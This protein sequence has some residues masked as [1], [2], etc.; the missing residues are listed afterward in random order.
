M[1]FEDEGKKRTV[2]LRCDVLLLHRRS[3]SA[4]EGK[5]LRGILFSSHLKF[6]SRTD[7][8]RVQLLV[9]VGVQPRRAR[10]PVVKHKRV[11][12]EVNTS[13]EEKTFPSRFQM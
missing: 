7:G 3:S 1:C 5:L 8:S 6:R 2:T 12:V 9:H 11:G 10:A 13:N 4:T